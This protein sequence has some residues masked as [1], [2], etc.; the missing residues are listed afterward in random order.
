MPR[1]ME[2]F[3][4]YSNAE[5]NQHKN[6]VDHKGRRLTTDGAYFQ[7]ACAIDEDLRLMVGRNQSHRK[8]RKDKVGYAD[9]K[10][11]GRLN[12]N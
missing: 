10:S 4:F 2:K 12:H 6:H 7:I 9:L 1:D 5:T 11:L 8:S 3:G